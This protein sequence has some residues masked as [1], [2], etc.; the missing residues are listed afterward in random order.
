MAETLMQQR[1]ARILQI[2]V[3]GESKTAQEIATLVG[4]RRWQTPLRIY[5]RGL[6]EHGLIDAARKVGEVEKFSLP[7]S[8]RRKR[9]VASSGRP[10]RS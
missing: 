9:H 1:Q 5:L 3:G 6:A 2:L 10:N 7:S 8:S 4:S